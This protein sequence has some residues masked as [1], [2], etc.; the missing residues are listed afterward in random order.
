LD[1]NRGNLRESPT[2]LI[3]AVR[4]PVCL[5]TRL[6]LE[7]SLFE[8][9]PERRPDQRG[10]PRLKG[11]H[12]PKLSAL[13]IGPKTVWTPLTTADWYGGQRCALEFVSAIAVWCT[14]GPPAMIRWVL[15]R[16]PSGERGSQAFLCT[17]LDLEP[18]AG[19]MG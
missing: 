7:A 9:A 14:S 6:R 5:I 17:G 11:K 10:R 13:L 1:R 2:E 16:D 19:R 4:R 3:A 18:T 8:P 15:V 12:L